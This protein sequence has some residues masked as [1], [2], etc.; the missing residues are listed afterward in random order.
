M[1]R[2]KQNFFI[3]GAF[4]AVF[5]IAFL[6]YRENFNAADEVYLIPE[7]YEGCVRVIYDLEEHPALPMENHTITH[8]IPEGGDLKTSSPSDFGWAYEDRS[9]LRNVDYY[10]VDD[11]GERS[12]IN[13]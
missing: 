5:T 12:K 4:L 1:I 13:R 11:N 8:K 7:G 2:I 3:V 10:Y 6:I 9:G